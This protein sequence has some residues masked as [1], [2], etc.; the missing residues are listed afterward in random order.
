[1][2]NGSIRMHWLMS[3]NLVRNSESYAVDAQRAISWEPNIV[4]GLPDSL[5]RVC[6]LGCLQKVFIDA[7]CF[8]GFEFDRLLSVV[9][10]FE[11][12]IDLNLWLHMG[13]QVAA[14]NRETFLFFLDSLVT[15][16][17]DGL[18]LPLALVEAWSFRFP[19]IFLSGDGILTEA[20]A[21]LSGGTYCPR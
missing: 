15:L 20:F 9:V 2:T 7:I 6:S 13:Q 18:V 21:G 12:V 16:V 3:E 5:S 1:M 14:Q 11:S 4:E 8:A 17:H 10:Q 19:V